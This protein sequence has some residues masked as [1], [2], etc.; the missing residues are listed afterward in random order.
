MFWF[1]RPKPKFKVGALVESTP[2]KEGERRYFNIMFRFWTVPPEGGAKRWVYHGQV[3]RAH[4]G[5]IKIVGDNLQTE[6]SLEYICGLV[7]K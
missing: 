4:A 5:Q 1:L 7:T 6:D 3:L 2:T